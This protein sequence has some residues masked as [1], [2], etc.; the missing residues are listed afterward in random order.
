MAINPQRDRRGQAL[1][2]FALVMPILLILALLT[3][4]YGIIFRTTMGLTNL[5]REGARYAATAP[6]IAKP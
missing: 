5:S 4:Q 3:A 1:V 2:E 6:A